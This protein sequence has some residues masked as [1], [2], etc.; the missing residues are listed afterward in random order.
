LDTPREYSFIPVDIYLPAQIKH[1]TII[2]IESAYLISREKSMLIA[3]IKTAGQALQ[4]LL[5]QK[6][7][8][9]RAAAT[10]LGITQPMLNKLIR[11]QLKITPT[12]AVRIE[13]YIGGNAEQWIYSQAA[14]D[15]A[16]ERSKTDAEV[17]A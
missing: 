11:G 16:K 9:Q 7:L 3:P 12:L 13:T 6:S 5:N 4:E 14:F 17:A 2:V 8:S 10:K 1:D 15:L